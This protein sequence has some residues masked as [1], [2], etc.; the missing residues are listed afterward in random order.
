MNLG[1]KLNETIQKMLLLFSLAISLGAVGWLRQR[2]GISLPIKDLVNFI[3]LLWWVIVI[4]WFLG[5]RKK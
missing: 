5:P 3:I 4:Y 2:R 1:M